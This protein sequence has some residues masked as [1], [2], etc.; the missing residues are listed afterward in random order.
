VRLNV[1]SYRFTRLLLV[2]ENSLVM[3]CENFMKNRRF[4][5]THWDHVI[6]K[7]REVERHVSL[8]DTSCQNIFSRVRKLAPGHSFLDFIH[9]L[10]LE[11]EGEIG[12]HV[13]NTECFGDVISGLSLLSDSVMVFRHIE[14][15]TTVEVFLPRY[16]LYFIKGDV[17]YKYKH[18]I[19]NEAYEFDG[20]IVSKNRRISILMRSSIPPRETE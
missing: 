11:L 9:V 6:S 3:H 16:S 12:P 19:L 7:Y 15:D 2:E 17:R 4:E 8:W 10:D 1:V 20:K 13:D 14:H 5:K 18:S